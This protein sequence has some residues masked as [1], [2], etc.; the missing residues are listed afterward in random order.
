MTERLQWP[1]ELTET[2][3]VAAVRKV[4]KPPHPAF[5]GERFAL[6]IAART[7]DQVAELI[8][9]MDEED[10]DSLVDFLVAAEAALNGRLALVRTAMARL[11]VVGD[12]VE[13]DNGRE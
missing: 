2:E 4:S 7:P 10:G 6:N 1:N 13:V 11:S 3:L 9:S 5:V 8:K 12:A